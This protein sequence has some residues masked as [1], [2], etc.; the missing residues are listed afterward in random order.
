MKTAFDHENLNVY[1]AAI[2]FVVWSDTLLESIPKSLA[3]HNQLDRAA[4]SIPLNIAEGNGKYTP[5][6][7]CRFSAF[8]RI[9][10]ITLHEKE[11]RLITSKMTGQKSI[12]NHNLNPN[13][14][15]NS[16]PNHNNKKEEK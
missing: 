7:R 2:E 5:A 4:T 12:P 10:L 16:N 14:N 11:S 6:D 3:V 15:P 9:R 1:Q 13:R 8:M